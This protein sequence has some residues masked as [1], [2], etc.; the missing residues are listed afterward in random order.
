VRADQTSDGA[1][2]DDPEYLAEHLRAA[3]ATDGRVLQPGLEVRVT[4]DLVVVRGCVPTEGVREAV[5]VV[6]H[7]H[8]AGW[9]V[10][11]EVEVT[12]NVEPLDAEDIP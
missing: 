2:G 11:N 7:D 9:E 1:R 8:A 10:V 6:V 5:G 3:L 4:R 12:P